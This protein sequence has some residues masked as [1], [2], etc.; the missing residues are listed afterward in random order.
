MTP[1]WTESDQNVLLIKGIISNKSQHAL[2][3]ESLHVKV[4]IVIDPSESPQEPCS[5][6]DRDFVDDASHHLLL[7]SVVKPGRPGVRVASQLLNFFEGY[8]LRQQVRDSGH[9]KGMG[10]QKY[11]KA[12]VAHAPLDHPAHVV[13]RHCRGLEVAASSA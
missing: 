7:P 9:P 11:G 5:L 8:T 1:P 4:L 2:H 6:L 13:G 12:D 3:Q 10:R